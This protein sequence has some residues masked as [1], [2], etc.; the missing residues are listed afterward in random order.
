[1]S[2][3][4]PFHP[5]LVAAF[6]VLSLFSTNQSLVPLEQL[7]RPLGFAVLGGF[8]LWALASLVFRNFERG[9]MVA[10]GLIIG[11]FSFGWLFSLLGLSGPG[12][13]NTSLTIWAV[14]VLALTALLAWR[15]KLTQVFNVLAT[16]L[17][18]VTVGRAAL[19]QL[20]SAKP[21]TTASSGSAIPASGRRPD[22]FY[23]IL[24]GYGR[25]DSL[26]RAIG[27]DNSEFIAGLEKRG[28]YVAP[29]SRAN[30]CQ[31]ELSISS[32]LNMSFIPDLFPNGFPRGLD[33]GPLAS[34]IGDNAAVRE[35]R[36]QGYS[37]IS[38][39]TGFPP[40]TLENADL[41]VEGERQGIT[42]V[43]SALIQMTPWSL[44]STANESQFKVRAHRLT[45][46][47]DALAS[48]GGKT[49]QPRFVLAHILAPHPPFVFDADGNFVRQKGPYGFWDGSDF[50]AYA[51]DDAVY[52]KGYSGQAAYLDRRILGI[53]D[54]LLATPGPRPII[55]IQGD[56]GSKMGLDQNSL[57]KTDVKEVFPILNAYLV[58]D[59]VRKRIEPGITP[60]NTF[61]ILYSELF[62]LDLPPLPNRSWYSAYAEPYQF[63]EVTKQVP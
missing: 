20:Q 33:R 59:A 41:Y 26:K 31:T 43:E 50:N 48:L 63:T 12:S 49:A 37:V 5:P 47:F 36:R 35:A 10:S 14:V 55:V 57:E 1:L 34:L 56:H 38:V 27:F 61:R 6:P 29:E 21:P 9:G 51:G 4:R 13:I 39:G 3:V 15:P 18:V 58:P 42:L 7:W 54:R 16:M 60:V 40:V 11:I 45:Y 2:R 46:A 22:I 53:V 44:Q 24:D 32:A 62:G 25:H 23:I 30:Y 17:L 52:R 8:A 19:G 28:F